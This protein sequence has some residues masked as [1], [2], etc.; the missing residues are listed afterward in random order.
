MYNKQKIYANK[1]GEEITHMKHHPLDQ[2]P[3]MSHHI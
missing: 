3:E 2:V 1:D